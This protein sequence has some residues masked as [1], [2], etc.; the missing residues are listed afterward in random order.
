V[1][2]CGRRARR[3]PAFRPRPDDA[4]VAAHDVD[5]LSQLVER[6]TTEEDAESRPAIVAFDT[7]R[8]EVDRHAVDPRH[9]GRAAH[10]TELQ[11]LEGPAV[12]ANP[13]LPEE[14]RATDRQEDADRDREQQR[15]Q[16]DERQQRD[17][18]IDRVLDVEAPRGR[19]TGW[20]DRSGTPPRWSIDMSRGSRSK[21]RGTSETRMPRRL[22]SSTMR[23]ITS[24]GASRR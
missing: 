23:S 13:P 1:A 9:G 24:C 2:R 6:R 12:S 3:T 17:E 5:Q 4:H 16:H 20:I 15:S 10:R 14:D 21:R 11:H 22:H 8:A 7:A 18:P 19:R